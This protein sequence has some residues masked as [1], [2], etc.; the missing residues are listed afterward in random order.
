MS[1]VAHADDLLYIFDT[2]Q[3]LTGVDMQVSQQ[4]AKAWT[5]FATYG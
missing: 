3:T 1:G 5:N 4:M 2:A